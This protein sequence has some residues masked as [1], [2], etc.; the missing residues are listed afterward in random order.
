MRNV[1]L[2][3]TSTS[4]ARCFKIVAVSGALERW[5]CHPPRPEFDCSLEKIDY[6]GHHPEPAS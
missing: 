2:D 4:P 6:N 5:P 3:R 1:A